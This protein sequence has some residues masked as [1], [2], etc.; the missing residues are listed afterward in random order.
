MQRTTGL[1]ARQNAYDRLR[2]LVLTD[3]S[4]Q[5]TFLNEVDLVERFGLSRTPIREAL[6]MLASDGLVEL[7]THRGAYV[8]PSDDRSIRE[9]MEMRTLIELEA[10]RQILASGQAPVRIMSDLLEEQA[11]LDVSPETLPDF[12]S[13]DQKFHAAMVDAPGN[14]VMSDFYTRLR[15]MHVRFGISATWTSPRRPAEVLEEHTRILDALKAGDADAAEAAIRHHI[16]RT[17]CLLLD[18]VR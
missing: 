16:E 3:P 10:A 14:R 9:T 11:R 15:V 7:I 17:Q 12:I 8:R 2:D 13:I 1:T 18:D 6:I 4:V 5:G